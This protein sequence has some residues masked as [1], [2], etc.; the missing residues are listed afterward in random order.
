MRWRGGRRSKNIVDRRGAGPGR[1]IAGG[2][3]GTIAPDSF[4]HGSS[5][6]RVRWFKVGF[7]EGNPDRCDTFSAT[8]L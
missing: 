7:E 1:K 2:G 5:A 4:V 3:V 8:S 6:Q